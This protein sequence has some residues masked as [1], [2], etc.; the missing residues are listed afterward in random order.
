MFLAK[1]A[2]RPLPPLITDSHFSTK[3]SFHASK[4]LRGNVL[5]RRKN[6]AL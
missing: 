5:D 6:K 2:D 4:N 3:L 1:R